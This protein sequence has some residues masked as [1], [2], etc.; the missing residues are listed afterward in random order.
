MPAPMMPVLTVF[1]GV[2]LAAGAL[3]RDYTIASVF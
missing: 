1:T 3:R 2:R